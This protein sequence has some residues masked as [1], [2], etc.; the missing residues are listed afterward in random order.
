MDIDSRRYRFYYKKVFG[1]VVTGEDEV[2]DHV[3]NTHLASQMGYRYVRLLHVSRRTN[4]SAGRRGETVAME[5]LPVSTAVNPDLNACEIVYT[6]P[7][8]L[9]K[10]LDIQ[11]GGFGL[12]IVRDNHHLFYP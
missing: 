3:M 8:D 6:D 11:E 12:D 4:S 2:I 7:M 1:D 9:L 10:M 5:F